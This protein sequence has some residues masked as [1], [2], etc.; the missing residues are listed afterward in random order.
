MSG[1]K[2]K[3]LIVCIGNELVSDDG[4]GSAMYRQLQQKEMPENCRLL[5]LGLGGIDLIEHLKGEELLI[6]VDGV[7]LGCSPGRVWSLE[8]TK[9]P[10]T[11]TRPV[12]GHGIGVREAVEVVKKLWPAKSPIEVHLVGIEGECFTQFNHRLSDQVQKSLPKAEK[13]IM[14]LLES[15]GVS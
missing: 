12:S 8:W 4:V 7:Q 14:K 5:F 13:V 9:L 3:A 2:K 15:S 1:Y 10:Q 11:I 6:V